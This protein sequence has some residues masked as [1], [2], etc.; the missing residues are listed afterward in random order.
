[1]FM[2]TRQKTFIHI[3]QIEHSNNTYSFKNRYMFLIF[4]LTDCLD[5]EN[6]FLILD[7]L[8]NFFFAKLLL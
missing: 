5:Y 2:H 7:S 6:I 8:I 4:C 1:M 3:Q